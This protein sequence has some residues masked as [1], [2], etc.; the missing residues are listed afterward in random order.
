MILTRVVRLLLVTGLLVPLAG[1]GESSF[2]VFLPD[3]KNKQ[4]T[5]VNASI[6]DGR[7][8]LK[9]GPVLS[10]G[11]AANE[12][13]AHPDGRHLIVG[14]TTKSGAV[15]ATIE[16]IADGSL[17]QTAESPVGEAGGY[18][19]VDRTGRYFLS[20][21]YRSALVAT[22]VLDE[23]AVVGTAVTSTRTPNLEAH[24]IVT[25]PDNRFVYVPCVKNSNAIFQYAFDEKTGELSALEPFDAKPPAM[26]GPRHV[27]YH[28]TLP[29]AYFSNEQQLGVS[30]YQIADNGQLSALQ[31][32]TTVPRRAP[33]DKGKRDL[34][35]SS[36]V[37][38]PD[39]TRLF[40]AMRD[41]TGDEDSVFTFRVESDG[42]LSLLS[43][44]KVGDVPVRL[45]MSPTGSHLLISESGE[46]LLSAYS[47][48]DDGVLTR[49]ASIE[50]PGG[51]RDM[52]VV[53]SAVVR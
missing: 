38:S 39:G 29:L 50:L 13:A 5:S 45:L 30:V 11:F 25:T 16:L 42:K 32:A 26:F 23:N 7:V 17:R 33:F 20:T 41:F 48:G 44:S 10:L 8:S 18:L 31:H 28:P 53:A 6:V 21:H 1:A 22:H 14:G 3:T 24:C 37:V 51:S 15:A 19:S 47:V 27:V 12:A 49:A 40:V 52:V 4:L 36:I 46:S 34:S 2:R 43:R 9:M 35:A